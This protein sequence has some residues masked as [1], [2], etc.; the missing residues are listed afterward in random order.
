MKPVHAFL[1]AVLMACLF[2]CGKDGPDEKDF[3]NSLVVKT[4]PTAQATRADDGTASDG[5]TFV[6]PIG[7][8]FVGG[9]IADPSRGSSH[10]CHFYTE[11]FTKGPKWDEVDALV[12]I[13]GFRYNGVEYTKPGQ[14]V[15]HILLSFPEDI[16]GLGTTV[17]IPM[18]Q[19]TYKGGNSLI[20]DVRI[21]SYIFSSYQADHYT[22]NKDADIDI[23]I[24]TT[25]GDVIHLAFSNDVTPYDDYY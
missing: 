5:K 17:Q 7:S 9:G 1:A 16:P 13:Y 15:D 10:R 19:G 23:V 14:Y 25:T 22:Q 18:E 3:N 8:V 20:K 21:E 12:T 4:A 6:F 24:T 11:K 2:G